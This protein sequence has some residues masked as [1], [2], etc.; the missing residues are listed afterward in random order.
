MGLQPKVELTLLSDKAD[1]F[2]F[3]DITGTYSINNLGGYGVPNTTTSL[4]VS[5]LVQLYNEGNKTEVLSYIPVAPS[6]FTAGN[7]QTI[8]VSSFDAV[9]SF[10]DGVINVLYHTLK[11]SVSLTSV[12]LLGKRIASAAAFKGDESV[13]VINKTAY[14]VDTKATNTTSIL[15]L[16]DALPLDTLSVLPGYTGSST[17]L[18]DKNLSSLL[19]KRIG[20]YAT[21]DCADLEAM[22]LVKILLKKIGAEVRYD[23]EDL[24]GAQFIITTAIN[25]LK[26]GCK[27]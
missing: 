13:V 1:S 9:G 6:V 14:R 8:G 10:T 17:L 20:L 22:D 18:N 3:R 4:I 21:K 25:T 23:C 19:A 7:V 12:T 27:C 11:A 26:G 5:L 15:N 2:K 16:L 24:K